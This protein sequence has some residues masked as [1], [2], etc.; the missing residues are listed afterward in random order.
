[1]APVDRSYIMTV[2]HSAVVT[3]ALSCTIELVDVE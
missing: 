3:I 1:M 2:Y